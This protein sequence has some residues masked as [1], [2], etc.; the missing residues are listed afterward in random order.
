MTALEIVP[1]DSHPA[2]LAIPVILL[3]LAGWWII[4]KAGVRGQ[5]AFSVTQG[6]SVDGGRSVEEP[7]RP[8]WHRLREI[9][10]ASRVT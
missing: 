7:D 6:V 5:R 1:A 4:R 9:C 2:G 3:A 10:Y 8:W